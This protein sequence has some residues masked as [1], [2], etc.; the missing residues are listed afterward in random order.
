[1]SKNGITHGI[2]I[3]ISKSNFKFILRLITS[4]LQNISLYR[5][6]EFHRQI[7][8]RQRNSYNSNKNDSNLLKS[9]LLI[10]VDFKGKIKLGIFYINFKV[11][12][13]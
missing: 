9:T 10:E 12:K 6:I 7:A 2:Y 4:V 11:Q 3:K 5:E 8:D 1:M 13:I